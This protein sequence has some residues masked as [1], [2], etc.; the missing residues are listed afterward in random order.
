MPAPATSIILLV[1][2]RGLG[3]RLFPP[4]SSALSFPLPGAAVAPLAGDDSVAAVT[5]LVRVM[6]LS[7]SSVRL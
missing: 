6:T 2:F 1:L 7:R 4:L 3:G 5:S